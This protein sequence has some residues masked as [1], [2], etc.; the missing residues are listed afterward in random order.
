MSP[1]QGFSADS[2]KPCTFRVLIATLLGAPECGA[3]SWGSD[4][5]GGINPAAAMSRREGEHAARSVQRGPVRVEAP[6]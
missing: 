3:G 4:G 2:P 5:D 1:G 6:G